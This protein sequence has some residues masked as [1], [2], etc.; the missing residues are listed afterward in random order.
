MKNFV[1]ILAVL[2][3]ACLS[4]GCGGGGSAGAPVEAAPAPNQNLTMDV[5]AWDAADW[6]D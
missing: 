4:G 5:T 3:A 6:A 2:V 1:R